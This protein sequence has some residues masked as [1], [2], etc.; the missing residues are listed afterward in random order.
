MTRKKIAV[1]GLVA[2]ALLPLLVVLIGCPPTSFLNVTKEVSGQIGIQFVNTTPYRAIFTY[3]VYNPWDRVTPG[4]VVFA[5]LKL[6]GNTTST[7]AT[8][9]CERA[10]AVGTQAM[11]DRI[12]ATKGDQND[13]NFDPQAFTATVS[14]SSAPASQPTSELPTVGT[15]Q[16]VLKLVGVDYA[17]TDQLIF[18]FVQDADAPGGFRI[19]FEVIKG[20]VPTAQ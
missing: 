14:F 16:G 20:P 10:V 9:S 8:D 15:A 18:R 17:C 7:L 5:Q 13:P 12:I 19:D 4:S 3:G 6:E 1:S 11:L 2:A